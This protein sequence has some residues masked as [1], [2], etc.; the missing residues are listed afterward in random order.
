MPPSHVASKR[1]ACLSPGSLIISL[2]LLVWL[3]SFGYFLYSREQPNIANNPASTPR[4]P[5]V[6]VNPIKPDFNPKTEKVPLRVQHSVAAASMYGLGAPWTLDNHQHQMN[7]TAICGEKSPCLKV[8][9]EFG[10][11]HY[12]VGPPYLM[13][14][15]DMLRVTDKWTEFVPRV[16]EHYP[17]LLAEMYAYSM[18]AAHAEV[19]HFTLVSYMVSNIEMTGDEGWEH[20]DAL[21]GEVCKAMDLAH[22]DVRRMQSGEFT[23]TYPTP[24]YIYPSALLPH[25]LHYCQFY[26]VGEWGFQKRRFRKKML[27]CDGPLMSSLSPTLAAIRYKNRDGEIM[28]IGPKQAS[29]GGFMLC[30]V[31]AAINR[32]LVYYKHKMCQ[33]VG[34]LKMN[35][36]MTENLVSDEYQ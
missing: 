34:V 7:R 12:S 14:K 31:H 27:T 5:E 6:N 29:R 22:Q 35:F 17:E 8:T 3:G 30:T 10:E 33:D 15:G 36:N 20:V 4:Q 19:P 28:K 21:G 1:P 23:G 2:V 9:R 26:R 18:A 16:Y 32:M 24:E 13:H 11:K 25:V